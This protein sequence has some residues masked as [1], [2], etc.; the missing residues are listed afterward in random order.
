MKQLAKYPHPYVVTLHHHFV[1]KGAKSDDVYLNLVLEYVPET[2]YSV[3]KYYNSIKE[4]IPMITIKVYMYQLSRALA[5]IHGMGICHRDIKPQNLLIDPSRHVLKLCDFGS[6]K[7]LVAGEPNVAYICSRYYRAPEL[8]I[9]ASEY[10]TSID[11]WSEGCVLAEFLLG[12]PVFVGGS[13]VEQ[14]QE[15]VKILGTPTKEEMKIMNPQYQEIIMPQTAKLP[16]A[17]FF[18]RS[19]PPDAIALLEKLL[20]YIPANRLKAIESCGHSFFDELK[21]SN[22]VLPDG[23]KIPKELFQYTSEE[24][25]LSPECASILM[26]ESNALRK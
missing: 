15:V 12:Q 17:N 23:N 5:H 19:V 7:C 14:I 1:S 16:W 4:A 22:V 20:V 8:I 3:T 11:V 24:L 25:S 18:K 9:N 10:S 2:V 6:A 26:R 13:G 21:M